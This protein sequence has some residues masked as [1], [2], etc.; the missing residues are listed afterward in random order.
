M[1]ANLS[2]QVQTDRVVA[3]NVV[4]QAQHHEAFSGRRNAV[5]RQFQ[6]RCFHD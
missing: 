3:Q 2:S 6:S 5:R 1:Q 4:A